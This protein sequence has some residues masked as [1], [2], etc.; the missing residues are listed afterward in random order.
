MF[1][2]PVLIINLWQEHQEI[3]TRKL[4]GVIYTK[5]GILLFTLDLVLLCIYNIE[6]EIRFG[7]LDLLMLIW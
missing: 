7:V 3:E 6:K 4:C 2:V 5:Y 1:L